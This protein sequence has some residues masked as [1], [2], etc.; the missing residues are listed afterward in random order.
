MCWKRS[1]GPS[2]AHPARADVALVPRRPCAASRV[3]DLC[4]HACRCMCAWV[5]VHAEGRQLTATNEAP[6]QRAAG[7]S[8]EVSGGSEASASWHHQERV[9]AAQLPA[10]LACEVRTQGLIFQGLGLSTQVPWP[11][12]HLPSG[13]ARIR[14]GRPCLC[15]PGSWSAAL[16]EP[17]SPPAAWQ[18]LAQPRRVCRCRLQRMMAR[19]WRWG[20]RGCRWARWTRWAACTAGTPLQPARAPFSSLH[21]T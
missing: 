18:S 3:G 21:R 12:M 8:A 7:T 4:V 20:L 15:W 19:S 9:G 5:V 13:S 10:E 16:Y 11:P 2:T 6:L 17:P 14:N 1:A